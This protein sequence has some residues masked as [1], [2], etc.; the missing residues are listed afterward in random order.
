MAQ[1]MEEDVPDQFFGGSQSMQCAVLHDIGFLCMRLKHNLS[2]RRGRP[3]AC[4][5]PS[6]LPE[7]KVSGQDAVATCFA[8]GRSLRTDS[9]ITISMHLTSARAH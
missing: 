6:F 2:D 4:Q 9:I 5:L 8:A 3:H 1:A 7:Q